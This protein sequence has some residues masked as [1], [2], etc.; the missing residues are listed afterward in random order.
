MS[1]VE[2]RSDNEVS[3]DLKWS[4]WSRDEDQLCTDNDTL[5]KEVEE[6]WRKPEEVA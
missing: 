1:S 2:W 3:V 6:I 5:W 4:L